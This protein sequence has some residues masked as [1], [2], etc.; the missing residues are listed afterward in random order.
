[1]TMANAEAPKKDH[2]IAVEA[3][4]AA[5][6]VWKEAEERLSSGKFIEDL[7][8]GGP[9]A[10]PIDTWRR[11]WEDLRLKLEDYNAKRKSAA[12][13][14]RQTVVL[15]PNQ[16]RGPDGAST[17]LACGDFKVSS[18]T[19]R[20]FD[21]ESLFNLIR[22]H[23]LLDRLLSLKML[24]KDGKEEPLVKQEWDINYEGLLNWLR[25]NKLDDVVTGAYDEK[26]STP[27]VKGPKEIYFMGDKKKD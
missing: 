5:E 22:K 13:A 24:N 15:T 23:G 14:L 4:I 8:V 3:F 16:W 21:A 19:K 20:G 1:M 25:A 18:V 26:E 27:Q 12:D 9:G 10:H 17:T 2:E 11:I 7:V 6:K